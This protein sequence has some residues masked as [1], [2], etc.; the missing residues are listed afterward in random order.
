MNKILIMW[1]I[2]NN[3]IVIIEMKKEIKFLIGPPFRFLGRWQYTD[4]WKEKW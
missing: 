3:L 2:Y 1:A 4:R